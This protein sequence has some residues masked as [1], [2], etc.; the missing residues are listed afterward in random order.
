MPADPLPSVLDGW[1]ASHGSEL[2]GIRR[3]LH[4][5]PDL[6]GQERPTA[7]YLAAIL[8]GAGL[9]PRLL[10][11]GNGVICD[12]GPDTGDGRVIALR[13]DIDA[14]PITDVKDVPYRSTVDGACHAC[15][16][17]VHA[18]VVTGTGLALAELAAAG[19]LPG[20]VRLLLQ[21]CEERFPSGAP[22]VT[23]AGGLDGVRAIFAFHCDPKLATGL[24]GV[25]SGPLTAAADML[26]VRLTGRGGHTARPHL[27]ADLVSALAR[28]VVDVPALLSRRVDPRAGVSLVFGAVHAGQAPNA[29]PQ[30][31]VAAGT[32]RMLDRT[33]WHEI[34]TLIEQL[35]RDVTA[36]TGAEADIRYTRGVPP[37]INDRTATAVFGAAAAAALGA[38]HVVETP[39][40]MGGED[41][42]WYLEHVPGAMA[43]LG[44]GRPGEQLDLHQ[45][46]FDVDEQAIG[47]GV[48]VMV[49]TA[50]AALADPSFCRPRPRH[51]GDEGAT[52]GRQGSA[53]G[54][55]ARS[56]GQRG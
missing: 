37:V 42:A 36:G 41:F 29:I 12:V 17:D 24:V 13:G 47:H 45:A 20:R 46:T 15:G 35:V 44:V 6:S 4:A 34:P 40:S 2:I 27:T 32:V 25:R 52:A 1:L 8:E 48:R 14:L 56:A 54:R 7:R 31:G 5:H 51:R 26:E 21:P 23:A 11:A 49:H 9:A 53:V 33:A 50:L 18:T 16:H 28:V 43:R 39:V 38:E 10:P 19:A 22:E 3:H 30:E 55:A